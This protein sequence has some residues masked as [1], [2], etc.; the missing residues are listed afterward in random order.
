MMLML[1]PAVVPNC[2]LSEPLGYFI[3]GLAFILSS[4]LIRRFVARPAISPSGI[5]IEIH[6]QKV[7]EIRSRTS[8]GT[9]RRR[10][11]RE[12]AS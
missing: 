2:E 11:D 10:Q 8:P 1:V 5:V 7:V 4:R 9:L 12:V 3:S 6:H